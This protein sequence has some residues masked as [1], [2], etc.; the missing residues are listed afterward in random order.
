MVKVTLEVLV[1]FMVRNSISI[2]VIIIM[3]KIVRL[4]KQYLGST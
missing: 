3:N 1:S 2:K 4:Q